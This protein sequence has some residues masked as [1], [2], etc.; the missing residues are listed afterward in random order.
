MGKVTVH[1][2]L[3][4]MLR[5]LNLCYS[6]KFARHVSGFLLTSIRKKLPV[7]G[8]VGDL[9]SQKTPRGIL[10]VNSNEKSTFFHNL[11]KIHSFFHTYL[12]KLL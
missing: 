10:S 11:S 8:S 4:N 3:S 9:R 12:V 1:C 7:A 2:V 5:K 6:H